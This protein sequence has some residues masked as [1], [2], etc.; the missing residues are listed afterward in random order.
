METKILLTLLS[1][2]GYGSVIGGIL[3]NLATWKSDILFGSGL[4]FLFLKVVRMVI[5]IY[6]GY[7][8]EEI[9]QMILKKKIEED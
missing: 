2:I 8:R 5:K 1:W 7:K 4:C 3:L 6:Q 9:E